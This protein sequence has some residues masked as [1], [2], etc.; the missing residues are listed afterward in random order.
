MEVL[1]PRGGGTPNTPTPHH[2][3]SEALADPSIDLETPQAEPEH[4]RTTDRVTETHNG[5]RRKASQVL[6]R[7]ILDAGI[8]DTGKALAG[9]LIQVQDAYQSRLQQIQAQLTEVLQS[10]RAEQQVREDL[11]AG[12][13]ETLKHEVNKLHKELK[14][15]QQA[16][17]YRIPKVSYRSN[18]NSSK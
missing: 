6:G 17:S 5:I 11:H 7:P 13:I 8:L 15:A 2:W 18:L 10:W 12:R 1:E 3:L 16:T 4:N 9:L 14:E